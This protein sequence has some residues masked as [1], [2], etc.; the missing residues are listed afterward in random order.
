M[1]PR[2][3][4]P[5]EPTAQETQK[6]D[7]DRKERARKA[8]RQVMRRAHRRAWRHQVGRVAGVTGISALAMVAAVGAGFAVDPDPLIALMSPES[9]SASA[10][11][12]IAGTARTIDA[13]GQPGTNNCRALADV[14]LDGVWL[15]P[16]AGGSVAATE[17]AD[18]NRLYWAQQNGQGHTLLVKLSP[19]EAME[20]QASPDA[21]YFVS[22]P[23]SPDCVM[24]ANWLMPE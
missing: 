24:S 15:H 1:L 17:T 2:P 10:L 23:V 3:R 12:E 16:A 5:Q 9:S 21:S 22:G 8:A 14:A 4:L 11:P 18:S 7:N 6:E 20:V 19:D 13:L